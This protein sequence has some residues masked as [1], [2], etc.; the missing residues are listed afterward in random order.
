MAFRP[1]LRDR[2]LHHVVLLLRHHRVHLRRHPLRL[3]WHS[4]RVRV[5]VIGTGRWVRGIGAWL[6]LL[7]RLRVGLQGRANRLRAGTVG[8]RRSDER[9]WNSSAPDTD[10]PQGVT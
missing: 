6:L 9:V 2:Q 10:C 8:P 7:L 5:G 3:R 1:P 4:V